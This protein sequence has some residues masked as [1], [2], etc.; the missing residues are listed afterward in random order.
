MKTEALQRRWARAY[1]MRTG[2]ELTLFEIEE[3]RHRMGGHF[4]TQMGRMVRRYSGLLVHEHVDDPEMH[5]NIITNEGL[6]SSLDVYLNAATQI[7]VWY[8]SMFN[9]NVTPGA[10]DTA[11]TPN[12]VEI[13][14]ADVAEAVRETYNANNAASQSIDNVSGPVAQY[15]ADQGFT[16]WGGT[17][18]GGGT[19]AFDNTS[20]V[21]WAQAL[22]GTSKAMV[23]LDTI[24]IT[25][26][27]TAADV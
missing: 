17:M 11:A 1:G 9:T 19:D 15:I 20:G 13:T 21:L 16:A 6:N 2:R 23:A 14:T 3:M 25:Y 10:G 5:P 18:F 24:D 8:L 12:T 26:T 7:T 22:F 27:F 4:T